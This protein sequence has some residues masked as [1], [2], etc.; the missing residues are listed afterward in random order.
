MF[1]QKLAQRLQFSFLMGLTGQQNLK[2]TL[3]FNHSYS[4]ENH[5]TLC[6]YF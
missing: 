4:I 2:A 3:D 5:Y 1:T 6:H